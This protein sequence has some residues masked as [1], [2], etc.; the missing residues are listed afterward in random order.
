MGE[1]GERQGERRAVSFF[2]I[3]TTVSSVMAAAVG[4]KGRGAILGVTDDDG[5]QVDVDDF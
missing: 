1:E 4:G 3:F 5:E 2:T